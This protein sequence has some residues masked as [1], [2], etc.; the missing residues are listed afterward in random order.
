MQTC[1]F[2]DGLYMAWYKAQRDL[3]ALRSGLNEQES[4]LSMIG[5]HPQK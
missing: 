1:M 3:V 2:L 5:L 4:F